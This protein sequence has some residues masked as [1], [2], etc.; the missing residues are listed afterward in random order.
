MCDFVA[1]SKT[2]VSK[3]KHVKYSMFKIKAFANPCLWTT[4]GN[5]LL[6]DWIML[7]FV[8]TNC[9]VRQKAF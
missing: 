2:F 3:Q 9:S 6:I 1:L 5:A 7:L 4:K 8:V